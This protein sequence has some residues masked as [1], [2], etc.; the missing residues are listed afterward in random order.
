MVDST[1]K[2][3]PE[4][5]AKVVAE[6]RHMNRNSYA[7]I[8]QRSYTDAGQEELLSILGSFAALLTRRCV[9]PHAVL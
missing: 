6:N 3:V 8:H 5:L 4:W 9:L 7:G 2:V 1:L